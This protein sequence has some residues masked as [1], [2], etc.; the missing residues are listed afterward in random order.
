[1]QEISLPQKSSLS[2]ERDALRQLPGLLAELLGEEP[3]AL[4]RGP[5]PDRG[6]DLAVADSRGRRWLVEVKTTSRPGHVLDAARLLR[7]HA[8]KDAIPLLVVP[9]MS[10]AGARAAQ[11][12]G[13]NWVDLSGNACIRAENLHVWVQ[14]RPNAYPSRGRP[15]SPFAPKGARIARV[16]LLDPERWWR[17]RDVVEATGLDDGTV[18][19][20]V[21]RLDEDLL[22][23]I[24]GRE[25]RPRA[26]TL[27]L[28]AWADDYRFDRHDVV[29]GH[30]SGSGIEVA[31]RIARRLRDEDVRH[32]FTGLSAAWAM[33][34]FARFRLNTVYVAGDPRDAA[35]ALGLRR[36]ERGANVQ[37][38][39][40]DDAGV[41]AGEGSWDDLNCV[42]PAQ[43]YLDLLHLP[44]RAEDAAHHLRAERLWP[45]A[46]A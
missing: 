2:V 37:V 17:Q 11:E 42:S 27:L 32:A 18:S 26:P 15:S 1:M 31:R 4:T 12:G 3:R 40:P 30:L 33:D 6:G 16:L 24:R 41:F 8:S 14:G 21:R 13:V 29:T 38:V 10:T 35:D 20:I 45:R 43:V 34:R 19:R 39:G 44:E 22:L 46:D 36:V 5:A 25:L 28:D 7:R 9:Y 23:E